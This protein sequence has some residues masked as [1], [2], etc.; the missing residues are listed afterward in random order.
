M[1]RISTGIELISILLVWQWIELSFLTKLNKQ[2]QKGNYFKVEYFIYIQEAQQIL[3]KE[4]KYG[5][6]INFNARRIFRQD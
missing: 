1:Y 2:I 4:N 3:D 5:K 6:S